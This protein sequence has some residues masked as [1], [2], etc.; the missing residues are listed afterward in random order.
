MNISITNLTNTEGWCIIQA[1]GMIIK[2][3]GAP[4]KKEITSEQKIRRICITILLLA[5]IVCIVNVGIKHIAQAKR[6]QELSELDSYEVY[7][8]FVAIRNA[9]HVFVMCNPEYTIS[10]IIALKITDEYIDSLKS[11]SYTTERS[12]MPIIIYLMMPSAELPYGWEKSELNI[13]TNFDHAVFHRHTMC[14][15]TI[16]HG[17]ASTDDCVIEYCEQ[18]GE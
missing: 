14:R 17:A 9:Y 2:K 5:L 16:P 12:D 4:M 1:D 13:S 15:I 18:N 11:K 6:Q 3:K 8:T 7:S 10:D